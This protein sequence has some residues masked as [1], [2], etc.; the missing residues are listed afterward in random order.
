MKRIIKRFSFLILKIIFGLLTISFL[1]VASYK[2]INPPISGM[3]IYKSITEDDYK[4]SKSWKD[5]DE[6][7]PFIPLAFIAAEDQLFLEHSGFDIDAIIDAF[8]HNKESNRK[9][10]ASTI[11]QQLAKNLFLFPTKSF[12]RKGFE[13]YYTVLIELIWSKKRIMEIYLNV[14][15]LGYGVYGVEE[16]SRAYFGISSIKINQAQA[17]LIGTVLPNPIVFKLNKPTTYMHKRKSWIMKQ[18]NNLGGTYLLNDW[19]E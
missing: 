2:Y 8:E 15:E 5:I 6:I 19:Y 13:V 4:Y 12:I 1:W 17:A 7:S 10:G 9:R 18:M 16:A 14:V 11:S 3:M